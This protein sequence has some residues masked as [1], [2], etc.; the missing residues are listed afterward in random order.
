MLALHSL[1]NGHVAGH[2]H[3]QT[4][5]QGCRRHRHSGC[6]WCAL[7]CRLRTRCTGDNPV[8][9]CSTA[10]Q[11]NR[12]FK[13][14]PSAHSVGVWQ[15]HAPASLQ[16]PVHPEP[17]EQAA[18]V[19]NTQ[20]PPE[21]FLHVPHV[22]VLSFSQVP[23][24]EHFLQSGHGLTGEHLHARW[25]SKSPSTPSMQAASNRSVKQSYVHTA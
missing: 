10:R 12:Q 3:V 18:P 6:C 20:L 4:H 25:P 8:A 19:S 22:S 11:R 21:H 9:C 24:V 1:Q 7:S 2:L 14:E 5:H 17:D 15:M 23:V 16:V 13:V